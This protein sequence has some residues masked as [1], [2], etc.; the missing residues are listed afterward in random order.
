VLYIIEIGSEIK[1]ITSKGLRLKG[2]KLLPKILYEL[3]PYMYLSLGAWS[4]V[5]STSA[6]VLV[7]SV[8][9]VATGIIVIAMRISYRRE[10][11]SNRLL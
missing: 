11:R 7:A 9:F 5:V 4:G 3:L 1:T 6:I 8:L 10:I 2:E